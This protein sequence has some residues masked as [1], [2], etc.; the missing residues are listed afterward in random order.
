MNAGSLEVTGVGATTRCKIMADCSVQFLSRRCLRTCLPENASVDKSIGHDMGDTEDNITW[1]AC[2]NWIYD[3]S[4]QHD[5]YSVCRAPVSMYSGLLVAPIASNRLT[6][7]AD[8]KRTVKL[9]KRHNY[10]NFP[11]SPLQHE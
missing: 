9:E 2:V 3:R 8:N 4:R 1:I 11:L 10:T 7:T 6:N 5:F